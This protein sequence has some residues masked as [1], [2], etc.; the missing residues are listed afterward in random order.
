MDIYAQNVLD[1]Y[2]APYHK[3]KAITA[4]VHHHESNHACGDTLA[5]KLCVDGDKVT[6]Y[7]FTGHGCTI[8]MASADMLGDLIKDMPLS[9]VL[10]LTKEDIYKM[11]GIEVS[12]R[13]SKCALLSLLALQ[14]ALLIKQQKE[15]RSWTDYHL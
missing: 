15:K 13:R 4:N 10:A 11:L 7:S 2:K 12:L 3:D 8:S 5:L 1:R 14:N 9:G 6:D